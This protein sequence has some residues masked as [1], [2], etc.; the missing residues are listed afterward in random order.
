MRFLLILLL[1]TGNVFSQTTFDRVTS[2]PVDEGGMLRNA[3]AGGINFPW[4][5]EIDLDG[6][7]T[8]DIF[9]YDKY[10]NR[11]LT[12]LNN[13]APSA[14]QAW[15]YAPDY[16][17]KF[18]PINKWV[19]LYDYNCDGKAD[20]FTLSNAF[21]CSGVM[22]YKN[23]ST[24]GNL[25]W[26]KVDT[27]MKEMFFTITQNIFASPISIPHFVDYDNDGDM[28]ILGYNTI[29]DGRI[30]YHKNYSMENFGNCD[31][32]KYKLETLCLGNFAL[33]IGGT[34]V[35]QCFHCPCRM[36]RPGTQVIGSEYPHGSRY[37]E[38]PSYD[39][40][41]AARLDDTISGLTA[42]DL[43]GDGNKELLVGDIGSPNTL[44][45]H[46]GGADM[47]AQDTLF[48][49][50]DT[51]ALFNTFHYHTFIDVDNDQKKDLLVMPNDGENRKGIWLYKNSGTNSVPVFHLESINFLQGQ[52]IDVGA[53]ACPVLF[54]YNSDSLLDLVI[55]KSIYDSTNGTFQ[56]GLYLYRNNGSSTNPSFI[57]ETD[58]FAGLGAANLYVSPTYPAFGDLDDD[59]DQDMIIGN[60]DG[61]L[62][63][64]QN[65]AGPGNVAA[66]ATPV[67]N[68]SGIDIGKF[69]TPQLFDLNKDGKLDLVIGGQ[70]GFINY[71][72][73]RGT[74]ASPLFDAIPQED[75]LGCI[76]LQVI[77]ST[78]G[79]TVPFFYDS[80]GVT[81]LVVSN[82][83]GNVF[84]YD[85]IDGNLGGCFHQSGVLFSPPESNRIKFNLTVGGGDL[86]GDG[87]TDLV[88]G[89]STGGVEVRYQHNPTAGIGETSATSLEIFPNPVQQALFIRRPANSSRGARLVIHDVCG[90][91]VAGFSI[92]DLWLT[93]D[94]SGWS[95]GV[96][97]ASVL[98]DRGAV[99]GKFIV[100]SDRR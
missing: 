10:N 70:R 6:N 54:D 43:D 95:S 48:P 88:L 99:Q 91:L 94:V 90:R 89:Q 32:L 42:I 63:Y 96:Y 50:Y 4:I 40:S 59:G 73:N 61:T 30:V 76:N 77:G 12:F 98:T 1:L 45:I 62:H 57:F 100:A 75:T 49:N 33:K 79:Y 46:N 83:T 68:Y 84:Q 23:V 29:P 21:Q 53:D 31:S 9:L 51:P 93:V 27:C 58:D 2:I 16:A 67:A 41:E 74:P 81:R 78:D 82:E 60:E 38:E 85:Q 24:P 80:L 19:F 55:S 28:D 8:P 17:T 35:V 47:D 72:R 5:S 34:N 13:G 25:Q 52:M 86:N 26:L 15:D 71:F 66:F 65:T 39:P 11:I 7:G 69:A 37:Y 20:L 3:W 18:P 56:T 97:V 87:L 64:Y 92:T 36:R 14:S 44:M 22:A